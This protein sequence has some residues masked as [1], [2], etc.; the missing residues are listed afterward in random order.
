MGL[1][2]PSRPEAA[3]QIEDGNMLSL[4]Q[5]LREDYLQS[6]WTKSCRCLMGLIGVVI[7]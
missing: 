4:C 6:C 1:A 7:A 5:K 2:I 3:V